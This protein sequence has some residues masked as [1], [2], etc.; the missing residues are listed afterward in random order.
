[1]TPL[2]SGSEAAGSPQQLAPQRSA[3]EFAAVATDRR[4]GQFS[5]HRVPCAGRHNARNMR[6]VMALR[7]PRLDQREHAGVVAAPEQLHTPAAIRRWQRLLDLVH[8]FGERGGA[9][10]LGFESDDDVDR[11]H[12][13]FFVV[14]LKEK[15][16][17]RLAS[18][19]PC[20]KAQGCEDIDH[21]CEGRSRARLT[22]PARAAHT[23][24]AL[25]RTACGTRG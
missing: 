25:P 19:L 7:F 20:A 14:G 9:L 4:A 8:E 21:G 10:G 3:S 18:A 13:N 22:P 23:P 15:G 11:V 1:M 16:D 2:W 12:G 5:R 17:G 24:Q 6:L